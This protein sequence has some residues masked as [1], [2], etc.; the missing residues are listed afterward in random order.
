M[1]LDCQDENNILENVIEI[2]KK[3]DTIPLVNSD[4]YK[5]YKDIRKHLANITSI[6]KE[7][8]SDGL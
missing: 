5:S 7:S 4:A 8:K 2:L 6:I 3:L 1:K